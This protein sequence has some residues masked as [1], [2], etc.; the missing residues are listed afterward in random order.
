[1][2]NEQPYEELYATMTDMRGY[3]WAARTDRQ[4][5]LSLNPK[6]PIKIIKGRKVVNGIALNLAYGYTY[7]E[8]WRMVSALGYVTVKRGDREMLVLDKRLIDKS[9]IKSINKTK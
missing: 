7:K 9:K 6:N 2:N 8:F 3:L 5:E 4:W 1:M